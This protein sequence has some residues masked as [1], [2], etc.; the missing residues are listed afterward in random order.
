MKIPMEKLFPMESLAWLMLKSANPIVL[1]FE[2][3]TKLHCEDIGWRFYFCLGMYYS[4]FL[5]HTL[6]WYFDFI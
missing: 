5:L 6:F 3:I 2:A 1:Q 4:G